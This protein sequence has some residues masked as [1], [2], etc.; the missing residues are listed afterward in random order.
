MKVA[1]EDIVSTVTK[2]PLCGGH[3]LEAVMPSHNLYDNQQ[4]PAKPPPRAT[5]PRYV[6]VSIFA[7]SAWVLAAMWA[8]FG[9]REH[10][11]F[12]LVIVTFFAVLF[13]V[14]F[15]LP[16]IIGRSGKSETRKQEQG[17]DEFLVTPVD[18]ATERLSGAQAWLQI[19]ILPVS[20]AI[21]ATLIGIVYLIVGH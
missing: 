11:A 2:P 15:S 3:A 8:A 7:V 19:L 14:L 10:T 9:G 4:N 5:L 18:T 1:N 13:S 12:L 6:Y 21:A 20:L 16:A 17:V